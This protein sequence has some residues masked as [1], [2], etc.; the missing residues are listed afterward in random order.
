VCKLK[1]MSCNA[2]CDCCSGNCETMDTCRQDN[3]GVPRCTGATCVAAGQACSTS[4]DCC[5]GLPCVPN[6]GDAG[7]QF[8]CYP[9]GSCVPNCGKCT[10]N[11]D[12]CVGQTCD[13]AQGTTSGVCGP[14]NPP[15]PPPDGGTPA[16]SGPPPDGGSTTSDGGT[17]PDGAMP[18]PDAGAQGD[19]GADAAP[20][21]LYGQQC[22]VNSDC[23]NGIPCTSQR[24]ISP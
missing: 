17:P 15:P 24:C 14:C 2:S 13:M 20:C 1:T 19:S 21:A 10:I 8:I 16:D 4:A 9:G 12:C 3:V 5:G 11:A 7:P 22:T 18:P 6:P 23:C